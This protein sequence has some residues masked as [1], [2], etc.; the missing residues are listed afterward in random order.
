[1]LKEV[2]PTLFHDVDISS[3]WVP[4]QNSHQL[5]ACAHSR[6][7][8]SLLSLISFKFM[9]IDEFLRVRV[10]GQSP[11]VNSQANSHNSRPVFVKG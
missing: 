8:V 4:R 5:H 2:K 11:L 6:R 1:M 3:V 10:N 7:Q 9:R